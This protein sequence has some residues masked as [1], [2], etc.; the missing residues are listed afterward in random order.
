MITR[1]E[2]YALIE[3]AGHADYRIIVE[4]HI[5]EHILTLCPELQGRVGVLGT[6]VS[7]P[8][9]IM[10]ASADDVRRWSEQDW[11]IIINGVRVN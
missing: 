10:V 6:G 7:I 2:L 5:R 4:P 1:D 9:Q 11:A 3:R 8:G